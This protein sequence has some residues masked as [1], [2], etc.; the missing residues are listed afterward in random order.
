MRPRA[1]T[2]S[3]VDN[4]T[5]G[6]LAASN[7]SISGVESWGSRMTHQPAM[8][9]LPGVR[10]Y[11]F[12]GMSTAPGHHGN[13]LALP[14]LETSGLNPDI[15]GSLKT[16]PPYGG[17]RA[18]IDMENLW[19]GPESTVNPAELH[20]SNSPQSL[21]F[22]VPASPFGQSFAAMPAA[23]AT[24]DDEGNFA[25]FGGFGNQMPFKN[26]NEQAVEGSSP[27][28]ISTGS[29]SG[30]SEP[31][32]DCSKN[33]AHPSAMWRNSVIS[34]AS[35]TPNLP[36]DWS[37][38]AYQDS[39]APGELSPRL[40]QTQMGGAD[41][42]F[43]SPLSTNVQTPRSVF[44]GAP[45]PHFHPPMII[46]PETQT[47]S[48][49]ADSVSSSNRQSSMTS[50]SADSITDATRQALLTVL[51]LPPAH[52]HSHLTVSQPLMSSSLSPAAGGSSCSV[53]NVPLP[54][55]YDLQRY[56]AA[57]IKHFHPHL[58]FLHLP[59]LSSHS[60]TYPTHPQLPQHHFGMAKPVSSGGG[61][62]L[63]LAIAAIGA[64]YEY[65]VPA[66]KTLSEMAKKTIEIFLEENHAVN[67]SGGAEASCSTMESSD[68]APPL[69]LIQAMVLVVI[70]DHQCGEMVHSNTASSHCAT[71][72]GLAR[73]SLDIPPG[74]LEHV[75]NINQFSAGYKTPLSGDEM[76]Q[77]NWSSDIG[78]ESLECQREWYEWKLKEERKRSLYVVFI[79]SSLLV[80]SPAHMPALTNAE[81]RLA[82]PCEEEIW[83]ADSAE[84][85]RALGGKAAADKREPS[86]AAALSFLLTANE[87][88]QEQQQYTFSRLSEESCPNLK[89]DDVSE[90]NPK[91]ST[92]GC[93]ILIH[94]LHSYI[95]ETGQRHIGR[96]WTTQEMCQMHDRMEPALKAWQAIWR[97]NPHQSVERPHPSGYG[98]LLTD[99][100]PL[101]DMA[102]LGLHVNLGRAKEAFWHRDYDAVADELA[103]GSALIPLISNDNSPSA[104]T[105]NNIDGGSSALI[106]SYIKNEVSDGAFLPVCGNGTAQTYHQSSN[107]ERHLREAAHCAANSLGMSVQTGLTFL[108]CA[109]RELPIQAAA[110]VYNAAQI[111]AEWV[112]SVQ[113]RLGPYVG[114]IG[115][116]YVD[117]CQF[118]TMFL[119]GEDYQLLEKLKALLG[120]LDA[121][122]ADYAFRNDLPPNNLPRTEGY[123]FGSKLLAI[124]AF[125]LKMAPVWP[126]LSSIVGF[127]MITSPDVP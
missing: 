89:V 32:L 57:Y 95:W 115:H 61:G 101:L 111:L 48:N 88:L 86:F 98:R 123:G 11:N 28:I 106:G 26:V 2:I 112:S 119:D 127:G 68:Q 63:V 92:F 56:V 23:Q 33:S 51:S 3:H 83:A 49:S 29:H 76:K 6:L 87:R 62:L 9:G 84:S 66:S 105:E 69:W 126:G 53:S 116:D 65:E 113:E 34:Q 36:M 99:C 17:S 102:R 67:V 78:Y 71:L 74:N 37:A 31:M 13:H 70:H 103:W 104:A 75:P 44:H 122:L 118:P 35:L 93:L 97:G 14:K 81:I 45:H 5:I 72:V 64:L 8:N 55:T 73:R 58:P 27:S 90:R 100:I 121:K 41:Q 12:R 18:P 25:W 107:R 50:F 30:L 24:L 54:S 120:N 79:V 21:A 7:L 16:A 117:F 91:P 52:G 110:S 22:E 96:Q 46:E 40:V 82:L 77:E 114:I 108:D 109:S 43:P 60:L 125:M 19:L 20:F 80:S 85:W 94:A 42:Y 59:S 10:G 47:P 15:G 124:I 1:N 38:S 4:A 39:F